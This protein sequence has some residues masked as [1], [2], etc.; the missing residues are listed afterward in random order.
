MTKE[1][2][3]A[4]RI[5]RADQAWG[6]A[7]RENDERNSVEPGTTL[8]TVEAS[9]SPT[10]A[11]VIPATQSLTVPLKFITSALLTAAKDDIRYYLNGV[12]LQSVGGEIRIV[13]TDGH[14]LIAS[15]FVPPKEERIPAWAEAGIILP[16]NDLAQALPILARNGIM[17]Q[18]DHS[19]PSVV[20]EY[21]PSFE[22]PAV[23]LRSV[24]GFASFKL[25]PV[26]GKFPDYARVL[27]QSGAVLAGGEGE[28][29]ESAAI[30]TRFI[31]GAADVATRLGAKAIHSFVGKP[32]QVSVFTFDGAPDTVL[33]IMPMRTGEAVSDGVVKLLGAGS[34]NASVAALRA[35]VTRATKLLES[36][37]DKQ[38]IEQ[39]E[40]KLDALN[41]HIDRLLAVAS[42]APK[43]L[44]QQTA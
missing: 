30:D 28:V 8:T 42:N 6:P 36:S 39:A 32:D 25:I 5:T 9:R 34:I 44:T 4:G 38:E 7:H 23:T 40:R 35:H 10:P 18:Y 17:S 37:K 3:N 24:N 14:R 33:I 31:K 11:E 2:S 43:Q 26:D 27:D 22:A 13:G 20:I 21:A 12:F 41:E 16:R 15:R 1:R 19:E 29:M